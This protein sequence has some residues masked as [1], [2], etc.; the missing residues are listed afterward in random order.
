MRQLGEDLTPLERCL[1]ARR[2][3]ERRYKTLRGLCEYFRRAEKKCPWNVAEGR[4]SLAERDAQKRLVRP[5]SSRSH[6]PAL[7]R[8]SA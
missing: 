3:L 5:A 4:R 6:Q 1:K 7:S 8:R 2:A